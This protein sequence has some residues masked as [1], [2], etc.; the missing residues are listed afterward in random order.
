MG[1]VHTTTTE[2]SLYVPV[3]RFGFI[4]TI[5]E[6]PLGEKTGYLAEL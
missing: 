5:L 1:P 6:Y 4:R 3:G 2:I